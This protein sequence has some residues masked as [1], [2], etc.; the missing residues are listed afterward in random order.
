MGEED[1]ASG[2]LDRRPYHAPTLTDYGAVAKLTQG[3]SG[4]VGDG[5]GAMA[6]AACL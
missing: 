5:I 3:A 4:T 2:I 1:A 6:M